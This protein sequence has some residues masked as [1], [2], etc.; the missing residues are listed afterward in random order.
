MIDLYILDSKEHRQIDTLIS[1][2][3]HTVTCENHLHRVAL[4]ASQDMPRSLRGM[5]TEF[6]GENLDAALRIGGFQI[7]DS[8]IGITPLSTKPIQNR[9]IMREDIY[10]ALMACCLGTPYSF[11]SQQGGHL[12]QNIVPMKSAEFT[13]LGAGSKEEL[14]WHT[15]DAFS[16]NRPDFILLLGLRNPQNVATTVS[17]FPSDTHEED[18]EALFSRNFYFLPDSDHV[19]NLTKATSETGRAAHR[20]MQEILS[21]PLKRS[22]L[23]GDR[24]RPYMRIDPQFMKTATNEDASVAAYY[25][26]ANRIDDAQQE[27]VINPGDVLIIDNHRAVHGRRPFT[28]R[29]DGRDRWLKKINVTQ[30]FKRMREYNIHE[31]TFAI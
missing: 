9:P 27:I 18:I 30:D 17:A 29:Y 11:I 24:S 13:Q 15:E 5:I 8:R 16:D 3:K 31:Q 22:I 26:L 20:R 2:I 21:T 25:R 6:R 12:T 19:N 23:F 4:L 7:D 14:A 1:T 10:L 28:A